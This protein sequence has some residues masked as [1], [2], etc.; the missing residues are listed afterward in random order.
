MKK[1]VSVILMATLM[2]MVFSGCTPSE[3]GGDTSKTS[4]QTTAA[5]A[6]AEPEAIT[7]KFGMVAGN[8]SN[9]YKAA[10]KFAALANEKSQGLITVELFP[11]SQLGDDRAMIEQVSGDALHM[12][13][14][15]TAR[16]GIWVPRAEL[17]GLSYMF[18]DFA[19]LK[20]VLYE[21]DFGKALHQEFY[22]DNNWYI[23]TTAYNGTR[24]TTSNR[25]INS[26]ED[27]AGLKLRTPQHQPLLDY[28]EYVG[29]TPTPMAF[30]E[31]YLALQT[32]A[33]DAQENPL[34]TIK[35]VKFYEV[36]K[37]LAMTNHMINDVNY[38]FSRKTWEALPEAHQKALKEAAEEAGAYHTALF[39]Q[40]EKDLIAF[41]EGEGVTV[42]YPDLSAFKEAVK[43]S[44]KQY[45]DKIGDGVEE[46]LEAI[47]SVK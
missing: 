24:Q 13:L 47:E 3:T 6:A 43:P 33:V 20:R 37:Y 25:A 5:T 45:F 38:V 18:N 8:Q 15:E 35:A 41:F 16:F 1:I 21:T 22:D 23:L 26:M 27:M 12:T 4:V 29:A 32:N 34:S 14:A 30:T 9:E 7:L 42:T 44:Y 39:E 17:T 36:Q 40:E 28:A 46:A 31:V 19:H 10:E 11:N 2:M